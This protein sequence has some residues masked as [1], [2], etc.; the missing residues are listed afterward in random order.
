MR[1]LLCLCITLALALADKD[2]G[3]GHGHAH[4][5]PDH[6]PGPPHGRGNKPD[7]PPGHTE[8]H[9]HG[10]GHEKHDH[11][12]HEDGHEDGHGK[13]N[14]T[15][16]GADFDRCKGLEMDAVTVNEEGVPYFFKADHLY[17]GFDGEAELANETF[18]EMDDDHHLGHV[19]AAL[20]MQHEGS[21]DDDH[22]F[23]FLDN[24]VFS[25]YQHK[26]VEGF[27]KDIS[28]VFP[29]IPEH[30]DAAVECP[31]PDCDEESVIF[32]KG[33]EI[34]HFNLKTKAVE[35]KEFD[36][37]PNCTSAF[38]FMEHYF[39]FHGHQYSRFDP[40]T[41]EVPAGKYPKAVHGYFV[42][43]AK[44]GD[45]DDHVERER[46]SRVHLDALTSDH[47]GNM[48]AFRNHHFIH[49]EAAN[50]S[51]S[52]D[53]IEHDFKELH[54]DVDAVFSYDDHL[55]IIKDDHVHVY[56]DSEPHTKVDGYPKKLKDELA[57]EGHVDAAFVCEDHHYVHI[58]QGDKMV[59]V[60]LKA[61]PRVKTEERPLSLFKKVDAAM[62]GPNGIK[63]V[64]GNHYYHFDTVM[65]M[66]G[67]RS[68]PEQHR[69]STEL[70]GCDH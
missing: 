56:T 27:P 50:D 21:P 64:V 11:K 51:I 12:H 43:C 29:G 13:D 24:K 58:I 67:A 63:V 17:K 49:K 68:L 31:K 33:D 38:R 10:L 46:C 55:Y 15:H 25:Y 42:R 6:A 8:G 35:K 69:V 66:V 62:C 44:F 23:F 70:F 52:V 19:D 34:Y 61:S 36:S 7:H 45:D 59:D 30:L 1:L 16:H 2:K 32:F 20:H 48:F 41:G 22:I 39:C 54:G 18:A 26:L 47:S 4:G 57:V 60:D 53:N 14:H 28:E 65:L 37:M 40:K 9:S 5:K 3:Q